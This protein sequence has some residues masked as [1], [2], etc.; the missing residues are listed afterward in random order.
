MTDHLSVMN[1]TN[2]VWLT[3]IQFMKTAQELA[4]LPQ[5]PASAAADSA[6]GTDGMY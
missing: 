5:A 2:N 4:F 6:H 3:G 1:I